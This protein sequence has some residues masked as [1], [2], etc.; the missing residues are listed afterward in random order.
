MLDWT[1]KYARSPCND[2][3]KSLRF[4]KIMELLQ[5]TLCTAEPLKILDLSTGLG[6][7]PV[8]IRKRA[9]NHVITACDVQLKNDVKLQLSSQNIEAIE[10][11]KF[12]PDAP[13]PFQDSFF[14][15][16]IFTDALEHIIDDPEHV[17]SEIHRILKNGGSLIFTTPNF[18]HI[19]SR[20]KCMFGKQT[21][22]FLSE[23]KHFRMYTIDELLTILKDGYIVKHAKFV[24][25]VE[26]WRFV[27]VS[28]LAYYFYWLTLFRSSFKST[29]VIL[30]QK[31]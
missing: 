18:A 2:P 22:D 1:T 5:G 8:M 20:F 13:L 25:T 15:V 23:D 17:F 9:K 14:D 27:G 3:E 6:M 31:T 16:V 7:L 19:V 26:S 4:I 12:T 30:A 24:N 21:Q 28:K 29:L 11:V 10:G